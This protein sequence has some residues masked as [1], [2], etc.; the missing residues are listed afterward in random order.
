MHIYTVYQ[1]N[2]GHS[3]FND[4]F[5]KRGL[6]FTFL[7]VKFRKDLR[8]KTELKLPPSLI[9]VAALPCEE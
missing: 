6:I 2:I 1:K 9:S 5:S 8:R 3:Y 4:N 7:T